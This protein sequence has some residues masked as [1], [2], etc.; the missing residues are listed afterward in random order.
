MASQSSFMRTIKLHSIHFHSSCRKNIQKY[1]LQH[2]R[3]KEGTKQRYQQ[4]QQ[5]CVYFFASDLKKKKNIKFILIYKWCQFQFSP[6]S[7][8]CK[9]QKKTMDLNS[10]QPNAKESI[11]FVGT[12]R[13]LFKKQY[14]TQSDISLRERIDKKPKKLNHLI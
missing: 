8:W 13:M 11:C 3:T 7:L 6:A 10:K 2:H 5:K 1:I 9:E 4:Q 12:S 14:K